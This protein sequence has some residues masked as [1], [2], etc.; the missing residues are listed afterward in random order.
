MAPRGKKNACSTS[1]IRCVLAMP[2]IYNSTAETT[3]EKGPSSLKQKE[4]LL[5]HLETPQGQRPFL[6]FQFCF[7][8]A[9]SYNIPTYSSL[10]KWKDWAVVLRTSRVVLLCRADSNLESNWEEVTVGDHH[11]QLLTPPLDDCGHQVL[12]SCLSSDESSLASWVRSQT[13]NLWSLN[14]CLAAFI[15]PAN[16]YKESLTSCPTHLPL[17]RQCART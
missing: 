8:M 16:S 5:P 12:H 13:E 17:G 9:R 14:R 15:L 4:W 2:I 1:E 10:R 11:P 6:W 3:E 7:H